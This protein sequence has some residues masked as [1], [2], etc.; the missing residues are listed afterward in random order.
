AHRFWRILT[1]VH[2]PF[3]EYRAAFSGRVTRVQL[4]WGSMDLN[5]ARF[6]GRPASAPPGADLLARVAHD[7]E[8][9]SA[10]FWPGNARFSEP[11]FYA[12]AYPAPAGVEHLQLPSGPSFWSDD[13]GELVLRYE[14]VR[15]AASPA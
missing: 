1:L 4:F 2:P 8:H 10:G 14:D 13:L 6:S 9:V 5:V 15:R 7:A 12:Y 3:D 11:A